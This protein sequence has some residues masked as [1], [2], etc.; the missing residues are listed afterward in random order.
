LLMEVGVAEASA[1][2]DVVAVAVR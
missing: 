2:G 1:C